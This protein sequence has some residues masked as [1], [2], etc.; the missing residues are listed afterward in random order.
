MLSAAENLEARGDMSRVTWDASGQRLFHAGVDRGMLYVGAAVA[1]PWSGLLSVT[2]SPTGGDGQPYYL[3]GQKVLNIPAGQDFAATIETFGAPDEF[4]PCAGRFLLAAGLYASDQP[5]QTFGFS[6]RTLIGNDVAG[7]SF[8]YKVHIVFN[9]LAKI[10][11]FTHTT[12]SETP[13]A[14]TYSFDISTVPIAIS[15]R[16]PTAHVVFDSRHVSS[17]TLFS[18]EDILYGDDVDD[19]R[20]PTAT[21][22]ATL[23]AT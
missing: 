6:Y 19:P 23:L 8:A 12:V 13:S 5:K 14:E 7:T 22:L 3:D 2:E 16:R 10:A 20:L 9:A 15:L 18:I 17:S 11:D 4:A 21:E 1:V